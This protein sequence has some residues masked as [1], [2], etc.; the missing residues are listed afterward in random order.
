MHATKTTKAT[1]LFGRLIKSKTTVHVLK[2]AAD[3]L[4]RKY[5]EAFVKS[6]RLSLQ[7]APEKA[8]EDLQKGLEAYAKVEKINYSTKEHYTELGKTVLELARSTVEETIK[9]ELIYDIMFE[10]FGHFAHRMNKA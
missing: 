6:L 7:Q 8:L 9:C 1:K 4:E 5:K 2:I 10:E 3:L